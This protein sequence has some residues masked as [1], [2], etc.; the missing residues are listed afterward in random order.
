MFLLHVVTCIGARIQISLPPAAPAHGA[1]ETPGLVVVV[2]TGVLD[3]LGGVHAC[4]YNCRAVCSELSCGSM[5]PLH[6]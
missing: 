5:L 1:A 6:D 3:S 4:G 2:V